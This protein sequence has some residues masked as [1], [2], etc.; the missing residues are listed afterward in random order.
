MTKRVFPQ[1][2]DNPF[3]QADCYDI[4]LGIH[5]NLYKIVTFTFCKGDPDFVLIHLFNDK[6]P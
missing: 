1:R 3:C 4:F 6:N 5:M 2:K